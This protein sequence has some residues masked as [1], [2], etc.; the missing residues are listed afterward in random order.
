MIDEKI[1]S[2]LKSHRDGYVSGE[3]LSKSSGVSRAAIWKHVENLRAEG[4]EIEATPHLG[5]RLIKIP[6]KLIPSEIKSG[7]NTKIFARDILSYK[8]IDST[9]VMAY[10]LAE[11]GLKEGVVVLAEE[12]VKGKGRLGRT[13]VSPPGC[14]IYLSCILRPSMPPSEIPKLTL[15]ASVCVARA[16]RELTGLLAMIKWPNDI[17]I[18]SKK[19]CGILLEMKAEQDKVDFVI[20]GIGV[21]VNAPVKSLPKGATSLK[22]ELGEDVSRVRLTQKILESLEA[23]YTLLCKNGFPKIIEEWKEYSGMLGS[24]VRVLLPNREFEGAAADIDQDGALL[25][26]LDNGFIE[27]ASSGDVVLI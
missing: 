20:V 24:R 13:W 17:L 6:D 5:Y 12:Q 15:T 4:Y 7:L 10:G 16:I 11:K 1:I 8:K 26:R 14:G 3:D 19:V 25:V 9:N 27:K 2:V 18:D 23:G 22:A 21:N